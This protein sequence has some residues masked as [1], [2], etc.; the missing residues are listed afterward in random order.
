[1]EQQNYQLREQAK[2]IDEQKVLRNYENRLEWKRV[3]KE[4]ATR[5]VV[6]EFPWI[7]SEAIDDEMLRCFDAAL[8]RK[9]KLWI[10]WG[11]NERERADPTVSAAVADF[12]KQFG[13]HSIRME[14]RGNTH[15]K[16]LLWDS[17]AA[18][19]A[20]FNWGSFRGDPG[21]TVRHEVGVLVATPREIQGLEN[22]YK[23]IFAVTSL[24]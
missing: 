23:K 2:I 13:V 6:M 11:F 18:V 15:R 10:A 12:Q 21:R 3:L 4:D 19:I 20:S 7:K 24:A 14:R 17:R 16:V 8:R 1:M 22:E 9:V 5:Y